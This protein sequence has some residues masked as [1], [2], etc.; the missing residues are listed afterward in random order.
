MAFI[1]PILPFIAAGAAIAG[2]AVAVMGQVQAGQQAAAV[3]R[4]NQQLADQQATIARQQSQT[5]AAI[6]EANARRKM[7][8]AESAY[9]AAG[10]D[11]SGTPLAVLTDLATQ[12]ELNKRLDIYRGS[13]GAMTDTQQGQIYAAQGSAQQAGSIFQA[14][15]SLLTGV[16]KLAGAT[17]S[18]PGIQSGAGT[19]LLVHEAGHA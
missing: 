16:G 13:I 9:G 7:G 15:S 18:G 1:A 19:S 3:G 11:M 2:T 10:V 6:D 4:Y 8:E 5:Q 12:S 14:G 17:Y